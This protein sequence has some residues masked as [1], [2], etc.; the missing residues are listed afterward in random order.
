MNNRDDVCEDVPAIMAFYK[1]L[2]EDLISLYHDYQTQ[3]IMDLKYI[4]Q[5][6]CAEGTRF[7]AQSLPLL[8]KAVEASLITGEP[9]KVPC[10]FSLQKDCLLPKFLSYFFD[11][12]FCK[13]GKPLCAVSAFTENPE[14]AGL[15]KV[16]R[17]ILSSFSKYEDAGCMATDDETRKGF[18]ARMRVEPR[19]AVSSPILLHARRLISDIVM[20][21]DELAA[22]L[23]Q[24]D[25]HPFGRHG[26]GA[27][28]GKERGS[29][30]WNFSLVDGSD[31]L[32]YKWTLNSHHPKGSCSA[33][34]RYCAVPKDF[35]SKRIICIEPK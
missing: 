11:K 5:R 18:L 10:G 35:R 31:P 33:T 7:A 30:K 14:Y 22:P 9:L 15:I 27:V 19:I 8:G 13:D 26:P 23:A 3:S 25:S 12:I 16:I 2:I 4:S 20:D 32:L 28:A 21:G 17:Q 1:S 34:S 6:C 24:W 29:S